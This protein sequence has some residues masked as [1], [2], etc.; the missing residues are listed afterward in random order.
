MG[1]FTDTDIVKWSNDIPSIF[2]IT[3][4]YKSY[5]FFNS[6]PDSGIRV[7]VDINN[8]NNN[9]NNNNNNNNNKAIIIFEH[10][11]SKILNERELT[12]L[13]RK[14]KIYKVLTQEYGRKYSYQK[15]LDYNTHIWSVVRMF[16]TDR[17]FASEWC[18]R[19]KLGIL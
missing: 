4:F 11:L 6:N 2:C 7:F 16:R 17:C 5:L 9:T 14:F 18:A 8:N 15:S 13:N 3:M 12:K 19:F 1:V 10:T